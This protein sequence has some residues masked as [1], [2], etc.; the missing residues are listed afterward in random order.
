MRNGFHRPG[1]ILLTGLARFQI[2]TQ[3]SIIWFGKKI[4]KFYRVRTANW[5]NSS[6]NVGINHR[7]LSACAKMAQRPPRPHA[8]HGRDP[9]LPEDY[10][11][12]DGDGE[13]YGGS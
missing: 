12:L 3:Y 10:C 9:A 2:H 13:G 11:G 6:Q 5:Q 8:E 7:R 4:F 1:G